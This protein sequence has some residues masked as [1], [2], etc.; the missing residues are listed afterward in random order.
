MVKY[1]VAYYKKHRKKI[2][3]EEKIKRKL[4][5]IYKNCIECNTICLNKKLRIYCS[6]NC[7]LKRLK[8]YHIQWKRHNSQN[9]WFKKYK[10]SL[11]GCIK[12]GYNECLAALDFHHITSKNKSPSAC[13]NNIQKIGTKEL[14]KCIL[15]CANCHRKGTW[16]NKYEDVKISENGDVF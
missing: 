13:K 12:C 9:G 3:A 1:W 4:C 7:R 15:L 2:L 5:K 14:A 8:K 16:E 10:R 6:N 11:G